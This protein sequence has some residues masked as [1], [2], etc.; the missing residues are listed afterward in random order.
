[1]DKLKMQTLDGVQNNID[2]I[3]ALFPN[4]I[5]EKVDEKGQLVHSIDFDKLRQELSSEIAE[6]REERY[7]F[8]WPNKKKAILLA[9]SPIN[10]TLRPCREESVDFDNT[11]NLYIEGDNLDVLKC[12]R[13]TYLGKVKMI[14]I[15]PPYNTGNDFVYDDDFAESTSEYLANSGQYDEQG[16]RLVANTESNGRFHTDWL[17]MIYPRLK[18]ARDLL[19]EDGVIFISIDD[20]EVVNLKEICNEIFGSS[21]F[22]SQIV[23]E[24][25]RKSMAAQIA[26]NHEYCLIYCKNRIENI[27]ND[28]LK[29]NHN[30]SDKKEGLEQIYNEYENLKNIYGSDYNAIEKGIKAFYKSLSDDNPAKRQSQYK[31]VDSKGLYFPG[32]IAQG[33]GNGGRFEILHPITRRP[34][35]LPKGGW[36]FGESKLPE[37][38]RE[39]RIHFG[40]DETK[41]PCLKRYLKETEYEVA[42]SVFYKDGRGA[43]KRLQVLFDNSIFDFPK[44]E[45]IIKRFVAYVTSYNDSNEPIIVLDFFSGSAT[46]AH[47]VMK[48]NAEVGGNRKFI[49]VQLPEKTELNSE[50]YKAGY[51]TICDI[52]KERIRRAGKK[53]KEELAVKQHDERITTRQKELTLDIGF[54]VLKLDSSNM[55]NVYYS[56][57]EYSQQELFAKTENVKSD[58]TGEDLLFQVMLELG[59]TLDSKIEQIEIKGKA[60]Y[61]VANNYLVACFDNEID[62]SVVTT[63][64]KMQP[65]YAVFRDSSMTDDSTATNFE[66][67]FKT[68]SP[69]TVTKVL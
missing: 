69:N 27:K 47:A 44:D 3:A 37:L 24:Q 50:A 22:V 48:L 34:C 35:K 4:C 65:Q 58:R 38:L 8:T 26:I 62:D 32:D 19:T 57:V 23:W 51:K 12:L 9:N 39:N 21:N 16:N 14:Y 17:N 67:I 41:V 46:T 63:I 28:S 5:T 54:R 20:N 6:G 11:Q 7:Q 40:E 15:D 52:G 18:V 56:P 45:E 60:I 29:S 10:A 25:G 64:A 36:R 61:N 43:S 30:W 33:T 68:Y 31:C 53:I 59:A 49:M 42:S 66:Q 13:E 55:E 2:K 1:M